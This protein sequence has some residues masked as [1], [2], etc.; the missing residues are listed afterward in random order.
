LND[1]ET[2]LLDS[3]AHM[4]N[5]LLH[6]IWCK[7]CPCFKSKLRIQQPFVAIVIYVRGQLKPDM[8]KL[9][10]DVEALSVWWKPQFVF[11]RTSLVV[12][13]VWN[14]TVSKLTN[15]EI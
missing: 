1:Q 5:N 11:Q 14:M 9:P 7:T 4:R 10:M 3:L 6:A 12:L 15:E 8:A 13:M 2:I